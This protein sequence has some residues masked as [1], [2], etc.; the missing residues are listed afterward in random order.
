[1]QTFT[2]QIDLVFVH[3]NSGV[4]TSGS[5]DTGIEIFIVVLQKARDFYFAVGFI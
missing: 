2:I 3:R 1:M 5:I 4:Y